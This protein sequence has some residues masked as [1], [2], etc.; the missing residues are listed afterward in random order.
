MKTGQNFGSVDVI[1]LSIN[2]YT[3]T[4]TYM[5]VYI[6]WYL[7]LTSFV[8]ELVNCTPEFLF[9]GIFSA[10]PISTL[11]GKSDCERLRV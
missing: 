9:F 8:N 10:F 3:H 4:H 11:P 2:I 1:S 5:Y 7:T 6:V